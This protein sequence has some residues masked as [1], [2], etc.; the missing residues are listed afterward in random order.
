M[1]TVFSG[2]QPSGNLHIGNYIGAIN[3]WV[4]I[5]ENSDAIFCI[6]DLHAITV[7]QDPK[8]LHEKILEVAALYLACGIDPKK[9]HLFIQSE[10]PDH[11]YLAWLLNTVTSIAQ[12]GKMTQFKEKIGWELGRLY[13]LPNTNEGS[14]LMR[15]K[16]ELI[17]VIKIIEK[18]AENSQAF[19]LNNK[20][21]NDNALV[22]LFDY[23]VLMAADILLYQADEVPVGEDQKQHI[24]LTRDLAEKFNAKFGETFKLPVPL[25]Q[26]ETAPLRQGFAGQARIMSLQ[27]P[28]SKMS[29]SDKD[30]SGTINLLDTEEQI[31]EKI[32]RAVT[33]S[34]S[35][36]SKSSSEAI[37]NLLT[38]HAAFKNQSFEASL[39]EL[40]G[41]S[42]GGFKAILADLLV[43]K[44]S[45]I[46]A[47]YK[48]IRS[49]DKILRQILNDGIDY[50]K[51]K[52]AKTIQTVKEKMGLI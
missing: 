14:L 37:K 21:R 34:G 6:V 30:P 2:I 19:R 28:T 51:A 33:D 35:S 22:G 3:Q 4:K 1:K 39:S 47:K 41:K 38:I 9:A 18:E 17:E 24:E 52:S 10:N 43:L 8:N 15:S 45:K 40:E 16:E 36:V 32:K 13:K 48:E 23:P 27:N 20:W 11:P 42:Y 29:K 50:V 26:K 12:L 49:D 31:R 5:Q 46:Q 7:P 25:I 44:L